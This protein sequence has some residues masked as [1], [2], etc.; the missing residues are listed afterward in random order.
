MSANRLREALGAGTPAFGGWVVGPTVIGPEEFAAAGY[1]YVGF[2]VQHGYLDDAD[3]ALLLR[4]LEHVPIGTAVRLPSVAPAPIGRVLDAG[5]DAVIIAMIES[6]E[7]AAAAVAATRYP[8]AGVRSYGPLRASLGPDPAA[9]EARVDVFAM[10]ETERGV[11]A[12]DEICSVPGVSGVYV[13]PADLAISLGHTPA[14]AWTEPA[15]LDTMA[16]IAA[17][18]TAAGRIAGI[19]A[20]TGERGKRAAQLG[21]RMITLASESQALRRGATEHLRE[22]E[23]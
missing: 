10:I 16:T 21:F 17:G 23:Q 13:G 4:R 20:G 19:H 5:A 3:V 12:L 2:D 15:V 1:H 11:R 7:Q 9:H 8:P 18:T 14:Q 22:A 6:A